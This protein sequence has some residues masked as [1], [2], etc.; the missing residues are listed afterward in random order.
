MGDSIG[1]VEP[2]KPGTRREQHFHP[3]HCKS[4]LLHKNTHFAQ[5]GIV[6][7]ESK[8]LVLLRG[9]YYLCIGD[10]SKPGRVANLWQGLVMLGVAQTLAAFTY[11]LETAP[12][13]PFRLPGCENCTERGRARDGFKPHNDETHGKGTL[14]VSA[15]NQCMGQLPAI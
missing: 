6:L 1:T 3:A 9:R 12:V 4:M 8:T 14:P 7:Q 2:R 15:A 10:I 11:H 13:T 5:A